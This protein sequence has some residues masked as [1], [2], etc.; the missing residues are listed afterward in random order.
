MSA[1]IN[2]YNPEEF[3]PPLGQHTHMTRVRANEFLFVAG[4]KFPSSIS[5]NPATRIS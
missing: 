3:G 1:E 2:I 5:L 4:R